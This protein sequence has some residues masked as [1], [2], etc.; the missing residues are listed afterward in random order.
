MKKSL[1]LCA[2]LA[3][4]CAFAADGG[5][6]NQVK[7]T[8]KET[9]SPNAKKDEPAQALPSENETE[10][11]PLLTL[12]RTDVPMQITSLNAQQETFDTSSATANTMIVPYNP[13]VTYKLAV[14][15]V[16]GTTIVLPEGEGIVSHRLGDPTYWAFDAEGD[17]TDAV[18]PRIASVQVL[19]PG[20]DTSL[21]IVGSSGNIYT[22]YLRGYTWKAKVDPTLTVY[23]SDE[24]LQTK[25]ES[26]KRRQLAQEKA[27]RDREAAVEEEKRQRRLA[28]EKNDYLKEA[29]V[30]PED[31]DFGYKIEGG[32]EDL[33]PYYVYDDGIFTFF[34]FDD[35][36]QSTKNRPLPVVY[37]VV[38]ESD[39]PVNAS[40]VGERTIRVE[41]VNNAWTLRLGEK[42]LCVKRRVPLASPATNMNAVIKEGESL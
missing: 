19:M 32:D 27:A 35:K 33:A 22:F 4:P 24:R 34:K 7:N 12:D 6:A 29:A 14:R 5:M 23:I 42:S 28:R 15:E 25:L 2:L 36:T 1:L 13:T 3:T 20:S 16:M 41:G 37:K 10:Q 11:A 9:F 30:N 40:T 21:T 8:V 26:M 17:D 39:S 18:L 38:D 31:Y